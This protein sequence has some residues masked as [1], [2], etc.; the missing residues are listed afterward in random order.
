MH[1]PILTISI[2]PLTCR[3]LLKTRLQHRCFPVKFAKFLKT[4]FFTEHFRWLLLKVFTK[5]F[6]GNQSLWKSGRGCWSNKRYL[7]AG[8]RGKYFA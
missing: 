8:L 3:V 1:Y 5:H 7:V 4:I 6:P 2:K